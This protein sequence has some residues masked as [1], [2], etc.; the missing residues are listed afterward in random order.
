M[1]TGAVSDWTGVNRF[2]KSGPL[3]S[4]NPKNHAFY[5]ERFAHYRELYE[6]LSPLFLK[7]AKE[8][9]S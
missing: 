5:N 8:T 2:I 4:P 9:E 3:I 6:Q 7:M 1:G